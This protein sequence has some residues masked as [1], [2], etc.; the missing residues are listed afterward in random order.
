MKKISRLSM[1][2]RVVMRRK[3][4]SCG[5][6]SKT[7]K[8][9]HEI[10]TFYTISLTGRL[11]NTASE[12]KHVRTNRYLC[13]VISRVTVLSLVLLSSCKSGVIQMF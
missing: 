10:G 13:N 11:Y 6:T 7:D 4:S 8:K 12:S 3:L 1:T 2:V 9:H 5:E